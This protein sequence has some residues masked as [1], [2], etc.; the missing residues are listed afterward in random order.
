M[1]GITGFWETAPSTESSLTVAVSAMNDR[2][3]HRG[4]DDGGWWIDPRQGIAL[5]NR[6]L[7]ILD[8]SPE[9]HQPMLSANSRFVLAFNGEIYNF[10]SLRS[11]LERNFGCKWRGHS[12]T[13]VLAEAI[14]H[15]GIDAT[16]KRLV[17]MFA[18]ACWDQHEQT[19]VLARDRAGEKPLYY[20]STA[21]AFLFGSELKALQAHPRWQGAV[22]RQALALF[23]RY[24][25]IPA[26]Y[27]IYHNFF[28]L[29]PGTYLTLRASD[30]A[31]TDQTAP[32]AFWSLRNV[33][34]DAVATPSDLSETDATQELE[35]LIRQAVAGQ[36]LADVP[37]GAFLSGGV[38]S[39]T[40]VAI[41]QAQS[42][43]PIKTFT[44][45]FVEQGYNEADYAREVAKHL[46]TD[47]T[48]LTVTPEE[49]QTVIPHLP[50]IYDEPFADSSQIPTY[51]VARLA[52][53]QVTVSLSGDGGDELFGGYNR[54][55]WGTRVVSRFGITPVFVRRSVARTLQSLSPQQWT[56]LASG[57]PDFIPGAR[58]PLLGDKIHKLAET[59]TFDSDVD[60]YRHY[61][62]GWL[63]PSDLVIGADEP[64]TLPTTPEQ[65]PHWSSLAQRMMFVDQLTYLPDD[66]LAKVDRAAMAVSL[67]TRVPFLDH[68]IIEFAWRLPIDYKIRNGQGKWLL[69][70]VL[71]RH[72]P[73]KLIERPKSGFGLPIAVWLRGP[74]RNWAESLLDEQRLRREG[75][76]RV[77]PIRQRWHEHVTGK[78]NWFYS[79]W[80]VL[81][82]QAWLEAQ[83]Q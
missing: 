30:I 19:L 18:L 6:R 51:L 64:P 57:L 38:D 3:Y 59:L 46:G 48:E 21:G 79:L 75:F 47:H 82:F 39:S 50:M 11:E 65:W 80:S 58:E 60:A 14:A 15:W 45:G 24:N 2:L 10:L 37:L 68:R 7:A 54:Y 67:E 74:L 5:A 52:R 69:R 41:M 13:E 70:Q 23:L 42:T 31:N 49:A 56:T 34:E 32:V 9:G 62:S 66:I 83:K 36:M 81:M 71:Y 26:P 35:Q 43:Q 53:R 22:N 33:A 40:I 29:P 63:T 12:D 17:G 28:K 20:G 76:L 78:R 72:V 27:T 16:L 8:L 77:A 73:R 55:F 4:P 44:I 61:V 25:Y 1:C